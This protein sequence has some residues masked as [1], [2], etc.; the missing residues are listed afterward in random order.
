MLS[1]ERQSSQMSKITND[2]LTLSGRTHV[3]TVGVKRFNSWYVTFAFATAICIELLKTLL[4]D[5]ELC[6]DMSYLLAWNPVLNAGLL[7][8]SALT[9]ADIPVIVSKCMHSAAIDLSFCHV[10]H[11]VLDKTV[12]F[13]QT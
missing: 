8:H 2:R 6:V 3:V 5:T 4:W 1:L 13:W 10:D 12:Q 11:K 7:D 9:I